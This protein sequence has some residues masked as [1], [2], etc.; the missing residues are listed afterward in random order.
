M[1]MAMTNDDADVENDKYYDGEYDHDA[2]ES[3]DCGVGSSI[4]SA[5][6]F[7]RYNRLYCKSVKP[8]GLAADLTHIERVDDDEYGLSTVA[9]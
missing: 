2:D 6:G 5:H 3:D 8:R 1:A 7:T 4:C 9:K